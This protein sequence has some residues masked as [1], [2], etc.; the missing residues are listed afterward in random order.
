MEGVRVPVWLLALGTLFWGAVVAW[1]WTA[2]RPEWRSVAAASLLA[3][4][5]MLGY[6]LRL[7]A[8]VE[9]H[10]FAALL[11]V[12]GCAAA[13]LAVGVRLAQSLL[14]LWLVVVLT[15]CGALLALGQAAEAVLML[16]FSA[17]G[18]CPWWDGNRNV[19]ASALPARSTSAQDGEFHPPPA[20]AVMALALLS[21]GVWGAVHRT[22]S[23]EADIVSPGGQHST[24]PRGI[25]SGTKSRAVTANRAGS[26]PWTRPELFGIVG[27]LLFASTLGASGRDPSA[28]VSSETSRIIPS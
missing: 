21:L 28:P 20:T 6:Q 8:T 3:Y 24:L 15:V 27:V 7:P 5:A 12:A 9:T 25:V 22:A 23:R 19:G 1:R 16:V 26:T 17:G 14:W 2:S 13:A 18:L 11:L 10:G 4:L